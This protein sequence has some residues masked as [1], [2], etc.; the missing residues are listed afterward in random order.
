MQRLLL[1]ALLTVLTACGGSGGGSNA[2]VEPPASVDQ[3]I[4]AEHACL[5]GSW[6]AVSRN[7]KI[8]GNEYPVATERIFLIV[9]GQANISTSDDIDNL[10]TRYSG[11]GVRTWYTDNG[12]TE[13]IHAEDWHSL[14]TFTSNPSIGSLSIMKA[15]RNRYAGE[16]KDESLPV[17]DE[18][19]VFDRF[20]EITLDCSGDVDYLTMENAKASLNF[21]R[22]TDNIDL[23]E[24]SRE[25]SDNDTTDSFS[26]DVEAPEPVSYTHLTL[27]T[28][29]SV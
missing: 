9:S 13:D 29:Y 4:L 2:P 7:L 1:C 18:S 23:V 10:Q 22:I 20:T 15:C 25:E 27:P 3:K 17:C 28:I 8:N 11:A 5:D 19:N 24:F 26:P 16:V 12:I 14:F 21:Q 6:L